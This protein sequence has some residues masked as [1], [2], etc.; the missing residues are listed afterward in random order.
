VARDQLRIVQVC[1]Y[2][3]QAP[4]GVQAHVRNLSRHLMR[5][6]HEV[7]VLAP[8]E[9]A[10]HEAHVRVV[11]R[12]LILLPFNGS[13]VPLRPNPLDGPVV[14]RALREFEPDVVHVHEPM[15]PSTAFLALRDARKC[16]RVPVVAT[17]HTFHAPRSLPAFL[18][19]FVGP[20]FQTVWNRVDLPIAVS[21]AAAGCVGERAGGVPRII[22]NGVSLETFGGARPATGLPSGRRMLFVGRL[23]KR[24]GFRHAVRAFGELASRYPDLH[25]VVVGEGA[26]QDEVLALDRHARRRVV[27][28][29]RV[30]NAALPGYY[31]AADL[32]VSPATGSESFGIVL[33]EAMA[34]GLP[35]VA[36]DIPGFREVVRHEQEGLLAPPR[37]DAGLA[38]AIARLLDDPALARRLGAAGRVRARAFSWDAVTTRVEEAYR[39]VLGVPAAAVAEE[40]AAG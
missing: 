17:F 2:G 3:W 23:E 20:L 14:R 18:Y 10:P 28:L 22:P 11:G 39:E 16:G 34:A 4:G 9:D 27:M 35:V 8:G 25:L 24:K 19:R 30:S 5:R 40:A 13:A 32:F 6:G 1:P 26:E 37:D 12:P 29:G 15:A 36:S 21:H 31:A 33:A 38:D 7:M